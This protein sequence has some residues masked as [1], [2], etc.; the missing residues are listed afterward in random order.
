ML[1]TWREERL[2]KDERAGVVSHDSL[3]IHEIPL[4]PELFVDF[5]LMEAMR[6]RHVL[7]VFDGGHGCLDG[8]LLLL[9]FP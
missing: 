6:R 5:L 9:A 3:V 4:A 2:L 8:T 7:H 1:H